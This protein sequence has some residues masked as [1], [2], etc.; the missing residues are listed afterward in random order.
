MNIRRIILSII[1]LQVSITVNAQNSDS[2]K[3]LKEIIVPRY[4][5]LNGVGHLLGSQDAII[6]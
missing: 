2:A 3:T 5:T 4:K 1:I 6:Y